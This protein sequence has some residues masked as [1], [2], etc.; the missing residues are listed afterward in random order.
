MSEKD[1]K[2]LL[3]SE[4]KYRVKGSVK[5]ELNYF[6]NCFK[7]TIMNKNDVFRFD[8]NKLPK[9]SFTTKNA[10]LFAEKVREKVIKKLINDYVY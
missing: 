6:D 7:I 10:I 4:I 8:I 5:V 3:E 9:E 2:S 1:F